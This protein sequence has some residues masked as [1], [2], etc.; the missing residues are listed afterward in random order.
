MADLRSEIV[1]ADTKASLLIAAMGLGLGAP[2]GTSRFDP[3]RCSGNS[4]CGSSWLLACL[5]WLAALG[6]L[7]TAL[8]PRYRRSSWSG[9][10]PV[11]SFADIHRAARTGHLPDAVRSTGFDEQ[12]S[13]L[14]T[15][16]DLSRIVL[17]KYR[18]IRA[19]LICFALG[20]P[21]IAVSM[22]AT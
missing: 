5:L 14:T 13:L 3:S 19:S 12:T 17:L 1:R 18:W 2:L 9:G 11:T 6:C 21:A 22:V 8:T 4:V 20:M 16:A 7:L 15:A 10:T